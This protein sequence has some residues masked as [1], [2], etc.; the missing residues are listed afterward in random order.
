MAPSHDSPA[1][2]Q[3]LPQDR[4]RGS[5]GLPLGEGVLLES[6][7]QNT[8]NVVYVK[9]LQGRYTLVNDAFCRVVGL[10]REAIV[11]KTPDDLLPPEA[12]REQ[13]ANDLAV[14]ESGTTSSFAEHVFVGGLRRDYISTKFPIRSRAGVVVAVGGI[15]TEITDARKAE[16]ALRESEEKFRL[17]FHTIPLAINL[18]RVS[19]GVYIDIN[20]GFTHLTGYSRADVL[21]RPSLELSIWVDPADRQRLV[22]GLAESGFVSDLQARFRRKNG[23]V[24][25]GAMSA[26]T[27]KINGENVILSITRDI[28]A[29]LD[30]EERYR[31]AQ[32]MEAIGRLAGGVA[33]DLNNLLVPMLSYTEAVQDTIPAEDDR[34]EMLEEVLSAA[35]RAAALTRQILA[36]SRKQVVQLT[37]VD[38]NE[39]IA[40]FRSMLVRLLRENIEVRTVLAPG[41]G[42][43][44]GDQ[45]QIEQVLMN[46]VLNAGDAM[47]DGGTLTITTRA[48]SAG[49]ARASG[50]SLDPT[51]ASC[52][53]ISVSDTGSGMDA[54]LLGRVFEP[55]FT[56]KEHG[57]GLGLATVSTIVAQHHGSVT[58][59]SELQKGT[60]FTVYLP[61]S[62]QDDAPAPVEAGGPASLRGSETVLLVEDDDHV[63]TLVSRALAANGYT[64]IA[65]DSAASATRLVQEGE[66]AKTPQLLLTDVIMPGA[67][68]RR[69]HAALAERFPSLRVL[70]MSGYADDVIVH[71][72]VLDGGIDLLQKPFTIQTLLSRVREVLD[73]R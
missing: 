56:T 25:I 3:E 44:W 66:R 57:T 27:M 33:H 41:L 71:H 39:L 62:S 59:Q 34:H 9:D 55:F 13:L 12:A 69:L 64:V 24:G 5:G 65:A 47:P 50:A 48:A 20:E 51:A 53:M 61:F 15:S 40:G 72:G 54:E 58:V 37:A 67:D 70:F 18:N 35:R 22:R 19:D 45:M 7:V 32:K 16:A 36:F 29:E 43:V 31:Q 1:P 4:Q 23:E 8:S 38:L 46:L 14:A 28:T 10:A 73:R 26:R 11:G 63:R 42:R 49:E 52:A 68:G 17:A 60:T 2:P 6:V 30:L 21:G